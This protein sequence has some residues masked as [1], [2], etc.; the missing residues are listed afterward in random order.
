[1]GQFGAGVMDKEKGE[2]AGIVK[3]K[4]LFGDSLKND[5]VLAFWNSS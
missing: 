5:F 3:A 2:E 1:L 4:S